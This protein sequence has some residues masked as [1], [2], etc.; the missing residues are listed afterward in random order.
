M[1][2]EN[3]LNKSL[4]LSIFVLIGLIGIYWMPD[5]SIFGYQLKKIDLFS[6]LREKKKKVIPKHFIYKQYIDSCKSGITCLEDYSD[7][8]WMV[9]QLMTSLSGMKKR[10]QKLRI[11]M[12]GDSFI[13]GDVFCSD[14][15]DSLQTIFGGNGVGFMPITSEVSTFRTTISHSFEGFQSYTIVK[16]EKLNEPFSAGGF[17][18]NAL[19]NNFVKYS[20][21]NESAHL[22]HFNDVRLFY[23]SKERLTINYVLD[24][25]INHSCEIA[26]SP[27]IQALRLSNINSKTITFRFPISK[28]LVLYGASFEDTVGIIIDNFGLRSNSGIGLAKI[29][30]TMQM[31]FDSLQQYSVIIL[32]YGLNVATPQSKDFNWYIKPMVNLIER[33]KRD[34]PHCSFILMSVSDRSVKKA[35]D[36]QTMESIPLM[37]ETQRKIAQESKIAFWD[38]YTAMGGENSMIKLVDNKPALANKDYTHLNKSGGKKIAGI[39]VQT[40]LYEL[41]KNE[42]KKNISIYNDSL[43]LLHK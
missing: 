17:C 40:L 15:R 34:Y 38:L 10:K 11:A 8:S 23:R 19:A 3:K 5:I 9:S 13:E 6:D 26:A 7:S 20:S 35:G 33:L 31:Q 4:L 37:V 1:E 24:D 2:E 27:Q 22:N 18:F 41:E 12:F 28:K 36:Y 16:D 39:F 29:S 32:Q 14:I 25:K 21:S 30:D 42:A 43:Q